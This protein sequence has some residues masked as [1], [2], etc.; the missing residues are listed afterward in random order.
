M[1]CAMENIIA[2][3]SH[4][5]TAYIN[6]SRGANCIGFKNIKYNANILREPDYSK[7]IDNPYLYGMPILYPVN[8]ISG[9]RFRFEDREYIFPINEPETNCHLHGYVHN[10]PFEIIQRGEDFVKCCYKQEKRAGFPHSYKMEITYRLSE[11]GFEQKTEIFNLS[12][13]NMPNFLGFHTTFNIPFAED[14]RS[15]DI[16]VKAAIDDEIERNMKNYL[17]TGKILPEDDISRK[18][19][20]GEFKPFE[21]IWLKAH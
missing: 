11:Y 6:V 14:S 1:R 10:S 8:R 4:N 15:D 18:I 12:E 5:Y 9:G 3:K 17:P 20:N 19:K 7:G 2:I 13:Q 16:T 21:K